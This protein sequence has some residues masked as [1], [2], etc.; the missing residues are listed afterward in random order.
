MGLYAP[1]YLL[2]S[3]LDPMSSPEWVKNKSA[4]DNA[5]VSAFF[6]L[7]HME[8][9]IPALES[10]HGLGLCKEDCKDDAKGQ[11]T[12]GYWMESRMSG[13]LRK[14]QKIENQ[15]LTLSPLMMAPTAVSDISDV[16]WIVIHGQRLVSSEREKAERRELK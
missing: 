1:Q 2:A 11:E 9:I 4:T 15:K 16:I 10:D 8:G 14:R 6:E 13:F 3:I 12:T 5:V 7:S